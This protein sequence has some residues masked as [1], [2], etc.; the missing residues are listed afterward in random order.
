[1]KIAYITYE[2]TG[3]YES[4][5]ENEDELL[6]QFL[7]E[8]GLPLEEEK[9]SDKNVNWSA[10]EYAI[11][12]SPWD[13]FDRFA[14]F[15]DWLN[16]LENLGIKL[17]NPYS[18]IRWNSDKH[19]LSDI[20]ES[21]LKTVATQFCEQNSLPKLSDFFDYFDTNELVIKPTVSG[22]SKNT[23]RFTKEKAHEIEK[24]VHPFLKEEAFMVQ[25]FIKE[26]ASEGEWS[27]LFFNGVF[28]HALLKTAKSGDFR[29]QH[30][31][32]GG[33]HPRKADQEQI[34]IAQ[35][36]VTQFAK[37]CLYARVDGVYVDGVFQLMELELIEPFLYLLA[38]KKG[39]DNYHRAILEILT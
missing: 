14:E 27:F 24:M 17:L 30:Y 36:Y 25:P 34:R 28:S 26:I 19:Y 39:Y 8:N 6:L 31:L 5:V 10:Y 16:H 38:E 4:S 3:K 33:I 2:N 21:G 13:Y 37:G 11:L 12:K 7:K 18:I 22:G 32:G 1:M 15:N 20:S 29:V 23:F 9:W 35:Q